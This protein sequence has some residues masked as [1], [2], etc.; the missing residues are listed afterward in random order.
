M[1]HPVPA[2]VVILTIALTGF[3][4]LLSPT[5]AAFNRYLPE[6][7]VVGD[8]TPQSCTD[9]ALQA[10][11]VGGGTITFNCG[12]DPHTL[13]MS[14]ADITQPTTV[15]GGT[16][17]TLSGAGTNRLF[18]VTPQGNLTLNALFLIDGNSNQNG[19]AIWNEGTLTIT[20][21]DLR[22]HR[23]LA[24]YGGAIY[25]AVGA[26]A[27]FINTW[28]NGNQAA[29]GGAVAGSGTMTSNGSTYELNVAVSGDGGAWYVEPEGTLTMY[30][31]TAQYNSAVTAGGAFYIAEGASAS[32]NYVDIFDNST[33]DAGSR[34]GGIF[35]GGSF[36]GKLLWVEENIS[37]YGGGLFSNGV[38]NRIEHS[39]FT[40]NT[41]NNGGGLY[42]NGSGLWE[43]VTISGNDATT[44]GGLYQEG[45]EDAAF[46]FTTWKNNTA[47]EG[48]TL[49]V[50]N[51]TLNFYATIFADDSCA[52]VGAGLVSQGYNLQDGNSCNLI[53]PT[54][55]PNTDPRLADLAL[56]EGLQTNHLPL[57][58]SPAID[59]V[60]TNGCP[61][62]DQRQVARPIGI[63]C[64]IG[65]VETAGLAPT[66]TP[67]PTF[68]PTPTPVTIPLPDLTVTGIEVTQG[69]QNLNN[70]VRLVAGKRTMVRV[71]VKSNTAVLAYYPH[72]KLQVTGA[73]GSQWLYPR[74]IPRVTGGSTIRRDSRTVNVYEFFVPTALLQGETTFSFVLNPIYYP[75]PLHIPRRD[76][77]ESNYNNNTLSE[78]LVFEEVPELKLRLFDIPYTFNNAQVYP[79]AID[80]RRVRSWLRNAYPISYLGTAQD[81]LTVFNNPPDGEQALQW[82]TVSW[83]LHLWGGDIDESTKFYGLVADDGYG[84]NHMRG[85]AY[86]RDND[87][88][89]GVGPSGSTSGLGAY[90]WDTDGSYADWYAGHEL[91]HTFSRLHPQERSDPNPDDNIKI[92]CGHSSEDPAPHYPD[93][94]ISPTSTGA[95]AYWG[96]DWHAYEPLIY[97]T[98]PVGEMLNPSLWADVMSYCNFQWI[99]DYTYEAIM[100]KLMVGERTTALS[101]EAQRVTDRLLVVGAINPDTNEATLL[102][103]H[104]L[105]DA[106][107]F[108]NR[109]AGGYAIVLRA[110]N[111]NELARYPF[112]P[113]GDFH[114]G[115][116]DEPPI[117]ESSALLINEFVPWVEGTARVEIENGG[118][119]IG[120]VSSGIGTPTVTITA[121]ARGTLVKGNPEAEDIVVSWEANDPD[122]D[123]LSYSV[124]Y[125]D[126]NGVSWKPV[127]LNVNTTEITIP[128]SMVS[129]SNTA[130][131]R[132]I[133][134]D[135]IRTGYDDSEPFTVENHLPTLTL[136]EPAI[137]T[138]IVQTQTLFLTAQVYDSDDATLADTAITW[139]SSRDGVLANGA[140]SAI[141]GLSL[142]THLITVMVD[143]RD[144]GVVSQSIAVEVVGAFE[145]LPSVPNGWLVDPSSL[146]FNTATGITELPLT[147]QN[148]AGPTTDFAW[149]AITDVSWLSLSTMQG[150]TPTDLT[151]TLLPDGLTEGTYNGMITFTSPDFPENY[152]LTVVAVIEEGGAGQRL[153]L[154]LIQR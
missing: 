2:K 131:L 51:G 21:S 7:T 26:N 154:P 5:F 79:Q 70:D 40:F 49:F 56:N 148:Q 13:V 67:L 78:T 22:N 73:T 119:V 90:L 101:E 1:I 59:R 135:G 19:G 23:A 29:H 75:P 97:E 120:E 45:G 35:S 83:G 58:G 54:D 30:N 88:E 85:M 151:V 53:E 144:G 147:I 28:F 98:G 24:G 106:T 38:V 125:S 82:L 65:A 129:G 4:L 149:S 60:P 140:E 8:G 142:G 44:G 18:H 94:L 111:G 141:T 91:G 128:A 84:G 37:T 122:G 6:N 133:A 123:V 107:D 10:A 43:N 33:S 113:S 15:D 110:N 93:A 138:T 81:R 126:D 25:N 136:I 39:S 117:G 99:S 152:T 130:R 146:F 72:A 127:A 55:I 86:T 109:V 46:R 145:E 95:T 87:P 14:S 116:G 115:Q 153:Y 64:D 31:N 96:W 20:Q 66:P 34:G 41:A 48:G 63:L 42:I 62:E 50:S 17:I 132:V 89:V 3:L 11:L 112:T 71:F 108:H 118:V 104:I 150:T 57:Q 121:P 52:S 74:I 76:V 27:H 134:S 9:A 69:I 47:T 143:D 80:R 137:D 36:N 61:V 124:L 77:E 139:S 16:L 100:D 68:S 12:A 92:E 32:L 105:P 102:P 114:K 103:L